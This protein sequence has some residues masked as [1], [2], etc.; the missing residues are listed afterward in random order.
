[1]GTV[2]S[3]RSG[4][5]GDI[6]NIF[7]KWAMRIGF[8]AS[9]RT[10]LVKKSLLASESVQQ[11]RDLFALVLPQHF[12]KALVGDIRRVIRAFSGWNTISAPW[13]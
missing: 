2:L 6:D 10:F 12:D 8:V 9:H 1:M 11:Q 7:I 3:P 13:L 4:F 5:V